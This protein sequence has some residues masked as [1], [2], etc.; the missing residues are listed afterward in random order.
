MARE[1]SL[2]EAEHVAKLA[3]IGL[4]DQEREKFKNQLSAI[5]DFFEKLQELNTSKTKVLSQTTGL[6]NIL[7][8]D[9]ICP[10]FSQE[11]ALKNAPAQFKGFFKTKL[12]F[13]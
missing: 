4:S 10:S 13:K 8:E 3:H 9:V 2:Q 11:E 12:V 7:R 6:K 5:L 1:L